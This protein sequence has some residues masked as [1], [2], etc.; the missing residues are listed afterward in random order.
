MSPKTYSLAR[1]EKALRRAAEESYESEIVDTGEEDCLREYFEERNAGGTCEDSIDGFADLD[2][3]KS[4]WI[5][6][7][8]EIWLE[9][10]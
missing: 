10:N 9:E 4:D 6:A 7:K 8:M 2:D 1:Y 3:L 5:E